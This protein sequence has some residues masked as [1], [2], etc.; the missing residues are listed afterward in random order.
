[1]RRALRNRGR[2]GVQ[3]EEGGREDR[4]TMRRLYFQLSPASHQT[5][6]NHRQYP[7]ISNLPITCLYPRLYPP[8]HLVAQQ[9]HRGVL[10]VGACLVLPPAVDD[11]DFTGETTERHC[12]TVTARRAPLQK[13]RVVVLEHNGRHQGRYRGGRHRGGRQRGASIERECVRCMC[14]M[15]VC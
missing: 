1:M 12:T 14:T 2:G 10:P 9:I 13:G 7:L 3:W 11:G 4:H 6:S 15:C 5:H 8:L